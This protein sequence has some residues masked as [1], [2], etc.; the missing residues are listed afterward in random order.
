[1]NPVTLPAGRYLI[2]DLC[3]RDQDDWD[4]MIDRIDGK[5]HKLYDGRKYVILKT[6]YGDGSYLDQFGKQYWV[7]SG[8]IGI[9]EYK[10]KIDSPTGRVYDFDG[11]FQVYQ[12]NGKLE[13]GSIIIDT[14][15][16]YD[17]KEYDD[18]ELEETF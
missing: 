17:E 1:M 8:T 2:G 14:G 11:P 16:Q 5:V 7:D 15:P 13:F 18:Y 12:E 3:Y 6:L 9:M 10:D 4:A